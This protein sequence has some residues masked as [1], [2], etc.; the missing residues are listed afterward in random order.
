M[1]S[2]M[3]SGVLLFVA[4]MLASAGAGATSYTVTSTADSGGGTLRAAIIA[5]NTAGVAASIDFG[6]VGCGGVCTISL[7]SPLPSIDVPLTIDGYTQPGASANTLAIGN[8]AVIL[9][10][11]D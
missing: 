3:R 9:I 10:S 7:A 2:S 1:G 8:D 5:A 11:L 4:G 6:I